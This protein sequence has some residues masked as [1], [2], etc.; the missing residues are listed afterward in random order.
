MRLP[1]FEIEDDLK[2]AAGPG[3]RVLLKAPTG[4]GKS[5]AVPGML[6]EAGIEGRVL[7]IEPRRMAAR[8]LAG[9]VARQRGGGVGGEVG[10]AVRFDARY[11]RDTRVIYLTDGVFQRWL[12]DDPE[13]KGVSAVVFDEF[14]ERRVAV[15][16]ALGRC[17][18]LQETLRPDLRVI[19]MS[20]TLETR[21]LSE[22]LEP[23]TI[24]EA[25]GR[26]YPVD[27]R[28]KASPAASGRRGGP[29]RETPV[30]ERV[31]A[32]CRDA[33]TDPE[34]G[35]V[36][37]FLPGA[38][39]IRRTL[40]QIENST[41]SGGW[42][43]LPLYSGLPP[44]AQEAA[45]APG[46]GRKIIV[47]TNVAETSL[48]IEGVR[49]VIDAG[50]ARIA[51]FDPRR[52]IGTLMIEKISRAAADQRAGRAGRTAPGRCIRLWSEAEHAR[53]AA[54]ETPEVHRV[55]LAEV[56]L[57]LKSAGVEDVGGFRWLEAP[58]AEGLARAD[59]LLHDLGAVDEN[60]AL[61]EEGRAMAGLPLEPRFARL[62]LA[63]VEEGCV[64][65]M[66]FVSAAV[67]GESIWAGR[68]DGMRDFVA[69]DDFTDFQAEWRGFE[70][71]VA[72]GFDPKR[73]SQIGVH[74]RAAREL[75]RGFERLE[76]LALRRGWPFEAV[77][78]EGRKDAVGRAMLAGFSD[79]LGVRAGSATLACRLVGKRKA[80]LDDRSAARNA[81]AFV[82]TEITEV[83]GRDV[84]V[85]LR[86]GTA[87][88]LEWLRDLFPDD[89]HDTDG[90]AWDEVRRCVVARKEL[91]FRDLVLAS[92]DSD[93]EV[94]LDAAAELLAARVLS[95]ELVLKKWDAS[96][97]QWCARLASLSKW[98]PELEL[99]GWGDEDRQAAVAQICHGAVRYKE[100]KEAP[101]WPVLKDWLSAPQR[102]AL[103][104]FAPE[105]IKLANGRDAKITYAS[106]GEPSIGLMVRDLFGV[107]ETPT[108][109]NG[110]VPLVVQ[111]QAPNR[112]PW[113]VTKDLKS[114]WASGYTQMRKDLA[115]RYPK[116][117]WPE[118]PK[119]GS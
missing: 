44:A 106:D 64:A 35:D 17:L 84:T 38:H 119:A 57:L 102:A 30:W 55:D 50:L 54:F 51:S 74:G 104:A 99:P 67:Q 56:S 58:Q 61:T 12:Q 24:L 42:S 29:A 69:D 39:E 31:A 107:W 21:G 45:V 93:H 100:I 13:L 1:V 114:F 68:G 52:G 71:A 118:D 20:A 3:G 62:M 9:W 5:T 73:V 48:T 11:G 116:H 113:Q 89:L 49:T 117:P 72:M 10:Y 111:V 16:V 23:V 25:G 103:D 80:K 32:A 2:A 109:A 105:R 75:S 28:Y 8:M 34:C 27:I 46:K 101:V 108:V 79:Q 86:R 77:D 43:V 60:G 90:A 96:V 110:H 22:F 47:S 81:S 115:G 4:S 97:D 6:L 63:G 37:C 33:I 66:A 70:S 26:T 76:K 94:N 65:E 40:S 91:R 98:M 14:H 88:E 59:A 19:V 92:K 53:R 36:L 15:D 87:V 95:G 78:F 41:W 85:H 82:A 83:E 7:V 18:D 112:R